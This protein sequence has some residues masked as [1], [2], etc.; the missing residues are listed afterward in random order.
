MDPIL[1]AKKTKY[2]AMTEKE[3]LAEAERLSTHEDKTVRG[4]GRTLKK[5]ILNI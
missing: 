1:E 5:C 4:F 2:T 3:L